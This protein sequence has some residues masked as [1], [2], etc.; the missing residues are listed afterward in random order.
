MANTAAH[1]L[2]YPV[3]TDPA[4]VP[5]DM[6]KLANAVDTALLPADV[7]VPATTRL[8]RSLL[9]A[10]DANGEFAIRGDGRHDWGV[11]GPTAPDVALYRSGA[12]VLTTDNTLTVGKTGAQLGFATAGIEAAGAGYLRLVRA[13][14][15]PFD[16]LQAATVG[17]NVPRL[18]LRQDGAILWSGAQTT[19]DATL[20]RNTT[21]QLTVTDH[22]R[23]SKLLTVDSG[24]TQQT[25]FLGGSQDSYLYRSAGA[26]ISTNS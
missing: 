8:V 13:A 6:Q 2:P 14:G 10:A 23:V 15:G 19:A 18:S 26:Q 25:L 9:A 16:V 3:P 5:A 24:A 11:G 1:A 22:L 21:G 12:G 4:D 7:V 17:D 20:F